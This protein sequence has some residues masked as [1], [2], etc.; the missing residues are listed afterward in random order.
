MFYCYKGTE[1]LENEHCGSDGKHIIKDLKTVR[2]VINRM[3][4][5]RYEH[6]KIYSYTNFYKRSTFK[7]LYQQ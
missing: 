6:Y 4:N 2:G 7:L 5:L 1:S 3:N